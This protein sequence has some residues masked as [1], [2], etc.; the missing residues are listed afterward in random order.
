MNFINSIA[1]YRNQY[2]TG[3]PSAWTA[4]LARLLHLSMIDRIL[5]CDVIQEDTLKMW[6]AKTTQTHFRVR[7]AATNTLKCTA[8]LIAISF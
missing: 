6:C 3:A 5:S 4:G 7:L 1:F 2:L 8:H